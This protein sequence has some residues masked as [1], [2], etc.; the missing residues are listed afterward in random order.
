MYTFRIMSF[1]VLLERHS[2]D[3]LQRFSLSFWDFPYFMVVAGV[4]LQG[5]LQWF[6]LKVWFSH[7]KPQPHFSRKNRD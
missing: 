7:M 4:F 2:D 3:S 6:N 1:G 5:E